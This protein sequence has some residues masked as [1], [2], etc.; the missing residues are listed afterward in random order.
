MNSGIYKIT[1][2]ITNKFYIGSSQELNRRKVYHFNR[3]RANKHPNPH[4]QNSYNL[5]GEQSFEYEVIKYCDVVELL[6]EEQL[7]LDKYI[8]TG[9]LF[10]VALIAGASFRNRRHKKETIEKMKKSAGRAWEGKNLSNE[11]KTKI[12]EKRIQFTRE[13][14]LRKLTDNQVKEIRKLKE[15]GVG[16][17]TIAKMFNVSRTIIICIKKGK[18]YTDVE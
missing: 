3:L 17:R 14:G 7:I 9:V 10:N 11:H 5:Y 1:C 12:A 2:E 6:K 18:K 13:K 15:S 16:D 4:M 8:N